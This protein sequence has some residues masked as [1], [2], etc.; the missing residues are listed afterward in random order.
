MVVHTLLPLLKILNVWRKCE[1]MNN[2]TMEQLKTEAEK[3]INSTDFKNAVSKT[4]DNKMYCYDWLKKYLH[5]D[6]LNPI[7]KSEE[8]A[9]NYLV[10]YICHCMML[11]GYKGITKPS[12][13]SVVYF[14]R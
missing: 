1:N 10:E 4:I 11:D 6:N 2:T 13:T 14:I 5:C 3:I 9:F 7:F 8:N 12:N